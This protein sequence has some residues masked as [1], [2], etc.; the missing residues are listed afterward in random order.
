V[1]SI[2]ALSSS[3][4]AVSYYEKD[5]Y[6]ETK[7]E[8]PDAQG[9]WYGQ[10]AERLGLDGAVGRD[11]GPHRCADARVHVRHRRDV[12]MHDRQPRDVHEL[13]ARA[14]L[15]VVGIDLDRN[16]TLLDNLL[17]RHY[18]SQRISAKAPIPRILPNTKSCMA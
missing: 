4:A 18:V 12:M 7:G 5:D 9:Q 13:L 15:H 10:G 2:G 17:D 1:L 8:N 3:G 6:Y 16:A 14:G 11:D